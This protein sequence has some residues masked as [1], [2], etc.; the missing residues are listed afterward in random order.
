MGDLCDVDG[1][2]LNER[3]TLASLQ[4]LV[5]R[6]NQIEARMEALMSGRDEC[7]TTAKERQARDDAETEAHDREEAQARAIVTLDDARRRIADLEDEIK[8][9]LDVIID[10]RERLDF[11]QC[12]IAEIKEFGL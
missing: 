7:E 1:M 11:V 4:G 5:D 8:R 10:Q 3:P 2:P 12:K 9:L 6:M